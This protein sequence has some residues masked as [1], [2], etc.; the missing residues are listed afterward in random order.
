MS[1]VEINEL[2]PLKVNVPSFL[3][4]TYEILEVKFIKS[5]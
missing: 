5:K 3:V 1:N 2:P 4:K